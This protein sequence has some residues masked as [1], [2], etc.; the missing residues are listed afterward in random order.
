MSEQETDDGV[1]VSFTDLGGCERGIPR[2]VKIIET[3]A[4]TCLLINVPP[5]QDGER[6]AEF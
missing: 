1:T 5:F 3:K 6:I 4:S 2:S